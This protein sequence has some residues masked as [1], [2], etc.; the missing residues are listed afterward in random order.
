MQKPVNPILTRI[1]TV[2]LI[3][4][5]TNIPI[6]ILMMTVTIILMKETQDGNST[7]RR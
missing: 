3:M 4:I 5:P 7:L 6:P 2:I 1:L